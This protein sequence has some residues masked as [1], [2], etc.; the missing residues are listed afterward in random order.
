[1]GPLDL[2][3]HL[4]NFIAP[5][6][7]VAVG[8]TL[9]AQFLM[10]KSGNVLAIRKQFAINFG[11]TLAVLVLGLVALG[12]DGKMLTYAAVVLAGATSQWVQ[13]RGWKR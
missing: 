5:A 13:Q 9:A 6:L 7:A 2:L 8:L 3:N 1:M 10:K 11:V 12:R 4:L